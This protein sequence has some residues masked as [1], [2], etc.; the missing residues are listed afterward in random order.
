MKFEIQ[1]ASE[2]YKP[3]CAGTTQRGDVYDIE[4]SSL[5]ELIRLS[6]KHG[7]IILYGE[8]KKLLIYDDNIE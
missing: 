2:Y 5:E 8:D 6:E 3:P 4:I 1:K 7:K